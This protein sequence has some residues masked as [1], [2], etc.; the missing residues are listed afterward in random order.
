MALVVEDGTG[1]TDA[2]SYDTTAA[3]TTYHQSIG[4]AAADWEDLDEEV[5]EQKARKTTNWMDNTFRR[6]WKGIRKTKAQA[7]DWPRYNVQDEDGYYVASD[8][9]PVQVRT[10]FW[11][12]CPYIDT[13]RE[14]IISPDKIKSERSKFGPMEEAVEY[15]GKKSQGGKLFPE[16]ARVLGDVLTLAGR[17]RLNG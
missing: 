7:K 13:I 2:E 15:F 5:K 14:G 16:V 12:L 3:V 6:R 1:K 10:A 9:V 11:M 17:I 4:T 8:S